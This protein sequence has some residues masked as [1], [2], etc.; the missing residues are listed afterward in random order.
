[1]KN[2]IQGNTNG[3][4]KSILDRLMG[5]YDINSEPSS[6]CDE[7]ILNEICDITGIINR[8]IAVYISSS[9]KTDYVAVGDFGTVSLDSKQIGRGARCIH[10]HPKGGGMLSSID[11]DTLKQTGLLLMA[12]AGVKEG[13]P[14]GIYGAYMGAEGEPIINGPFFSIGAAS[15]LIED[16]LEFGKWKPVKVNHDIERVIAAGVSL[17]GAKALLDELAELIISAGGVCVHM[18]EQQRDSYDSAYYMGKGK[19]SELKFLCS[20]FEADTIVFDDPLSPGQLRNIENELKV[21]ILDRSSLILDIFAQR[22]HTKEG[23][24]QV[25]LAQ[26]NYNLPRL[27]GLGTAL[28]RLG[29]GIGTRGPGESMLETDRRHVLRR[30]NYLKK[31]LKNI[32][33]RREMLSESRRKKNIFTVALA[34]YTNAGKS[35]LINRLTD[36]NVLA[37]DILFATLDPSA[38][39]LVLPSGEDIIVIDTVGFVSKLPHELVEAF[40]ST[41][42]EVA[43]SDM[44]LH[45]MDGSSPQME[46][47]KEIVYSILNELGASEIPVLEVVNKTDISGKADIHKSIKNRIPISA[48]TGEG[49]PELIKKLEIAA[50]GI[51]K[52]ARIKVPYDM[53]SLIAYIRANTEILEEEYEENFICFKL[54]MTKRSHL[55]IM[56]QLDAGQR[57]I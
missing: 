8:E 42:E 28:S 39:K 38:R 48:L 22:A 45:V 23:K 33:T 51:R 50:E 49:I 47:Q 46:R 31:E 37:Q 29:G 2:T 21:K 15:K 54:R 55:K 52:T 35:T 18:E 41:L 12:A 5:L 7:I 3:L 20:R 24:I 36:S 56:S 25:E 9:G 43:K 27:V 17:P 4:K 57:G 30:I 1:M 10:T 44:I 19:I 53:G 40:K 16:A 11:F 6:L 13:R 26:Q 14:N 32:Q 34:G